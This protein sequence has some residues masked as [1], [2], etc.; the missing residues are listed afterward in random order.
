MKNTKVEI[1][2][3]LFNGDVFPIVE[4]IGNIS[5]DA[6]NIEAAVIK[7][8]NDVVN[9]DKQLAKE[10][11]LHLNNKIGEK[12]MYINNATFLFKHS[13]SIKEIIVSNGEMVK[14]IR[15]IESIWNKRKR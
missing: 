15:K 7:D 10:I 14:I 9:F 1:E 2:F 13:S 8:E 11:I 6:V 3:N 12:I 5:V 4:L